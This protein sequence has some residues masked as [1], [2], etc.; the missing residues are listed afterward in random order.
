LPFSAKEDTSEYSVSKA[1]L[2]WL[3]GIVLRIDAAYRWWWRKSVYH[4][5]GYNPIHIL[6]RHKNNLLSSANNNPPE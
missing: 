2:S 5:G 6:F 1:I 4:T 3:K